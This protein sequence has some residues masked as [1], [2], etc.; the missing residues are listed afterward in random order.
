MILKAIQRFIPALTFI[1][2]IFPASAASQALMQESVQAEIAKVSSSA[3]INLL[4]SFDDDLDPTAFKIARIREKRDRAAN[5][6]A[7]MDRLQNNRK[8]LE[9]SLIPQ[10]E[11]MV[12]DGRL[13]SYRFFTVSRTILVST[14]V[15]NIESLKQLPNIR[16][17]NLNGNIS[18]VNPVE[19]EPAMADAGDAASLAGQDA[20][21]IR[22]LWNRGLT[23]KGRLICSF[24]TGIDGDH[25]ALNSNWRGNHLADSSAAWFAPHG[26]TVPDDKIG[27]GSH[28]MG[29]MVGHTDVDTIGVAFG[30]EWISAAVI[31]QGASFS[32]T[33]ADI[34]DAFDWALNPDGDLNTTDDV[35][36][37][38][39]NSWGVPKGI[40]DACDNTFWTAIDNIETAGIVAIFSAGNEGPDPQTIRNPADRASSPTNALAVGAIDPATNLI[41]SF[42]SRGPANCDNTQIKPELVAPGVSIYSAYKDNTYRFM[43]GTSM[44]APFIAGLVALM[45]QYNPEVTVA[46]IKD[47]LMAATTDLGPV[48]EDNSYGRG[49]VDASRLLDYLPEPQSPVVQVYG[50]QF[51]SGGDDFADPGETAQISLTLNDPTGLVDSIDIWLGTTDS[52]LS[53]SPDTIRYHF[54]EGS[55][56]AASVTSFSIEI[57]SEAISGLNADLIVH[58]QYPG[59][60]SADTSAYDIVIGHQLPGD[61]STISTGAIDLTVSDFAQF[62]FGQGSV[63][64]SGG[65][66]FRFNGNDNILYEGGLIVAR[67]EQLVSDAIR[68]SDGSFKVSD[69]IPAESQ[70]LAADNGNRFDALY[71]DDNS[72]LPIP[73]QVEQAV[74]SSGGDFVI[75]EFEITNP[76]AARIEYLSYGLFCDFDIDRFEDE[77]GFDTMMGIVYQ[78]NANTGVYVGLVGLSPNEFSYKAGQNGLAAKAGFSREQKFALVGGNGIEINPTGQ[79]DWYMSIARTITD[80]G[81]FAQSKLAVALV[82]GNSLAD[83]RLEAEAALGEYDAILDVEE[84]L[85]L[86]P[87]ILELAQNYPNPFNPRTTIRF[88]LK[89]AQHARLVVYNVAGQVVRMLYDEFAFA[90]EQN[91][92]WDG[93]DEYGRQ[94]ASGVYF[95]RLTAGAESVSKK[96]ILLK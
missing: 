81:A 21:N 23:G 29:V 12:A 4:L 82:A 33:I 27:H 34:L 68:T 18:L 64:Q 13:Q 86:L 2:A 60:F 9:I 83:L 85:A 47:A 50:H 51:N 1:I 71:T 3:Y 95:Y 15:D 7:V 61:I 90:G 25:E 17:I 63:Y 6:R 16:M 8:N 45:R 40:Y 11:E 52:L 28:V 30:A 46:E 10:F 55:T 75:F 94:V 48:G 43:S 80:M 44:A 91:V 65:E 62:G 79:N 41:A 53:I 87:G 58:Q 36:D 5:Y 77:I 78:Y 59:G 89:S 38:I 14:R 31:D 84:H 49:L 35:P 54:A 92:V 67:S 57:S 96:M 26:G 73:V 20:I 24:D 88:N 70:P 66:G 72:I 93:S 37:V 22:N 39:C 32:T 56:Y 42:S 74:Y 69:Y 76:T 19:D